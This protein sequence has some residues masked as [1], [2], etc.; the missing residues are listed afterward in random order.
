MKDLCHGTE[1]PVSARL[2]QLLYA[3]ASKKGSVANIYVCPIL[4]LLF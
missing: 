2:H 1:A 4:L 3:E